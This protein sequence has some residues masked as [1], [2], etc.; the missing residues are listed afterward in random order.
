ME[1]F[2]WQRNFTL[3]IGQLCPFF[4]LNTEKS[5]MFT[6]KVKTFGWCKKGA[7]LPW[8]FPSKLKSSSVWDFRNTLGSS[9]SIF[10]CSAC[11]ISGKL[12]LSIFHKLFPTI[13]RNP[14]LTI[15]DK[16]C[17]FLFPTGDAYR[18]RWG[19]T[20]SSFLLSRFEHFFQVKASSTLTNFVNQNT[21]LFKIPICWTWISKSQTNLRNWGIGNDAV[22]D[23]NAFLWRL[24][25]TKN[26]A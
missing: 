5:T 12:F 10:I 6:I 9:E 18:P 23:N 25:W 20:R 17:I 24:F 22:D 11:R 3:Q 21:D 14:F 26:V 15:S 4:A 13:S 19:D 16:L 1:H 8:G 7:F 2:T